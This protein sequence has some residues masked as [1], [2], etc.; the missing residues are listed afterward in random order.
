M[1][2]ALS[3]RILLHLLYHFLIPFATCFKP[4]PAFCI[5]EVVNLNQHTILP[6][7]VG[8]EAKAGEGM[9]IMSKEVIRISVVG[10]LPMLM[11]TFIA[12]LPIY[13]PLTSP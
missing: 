2:K 4:E 7:G 5:R 3:K 12:H 9:A 6:V 8:S 13:S 10:Y 11:H 1:P